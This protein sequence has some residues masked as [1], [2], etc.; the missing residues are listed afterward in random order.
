MDKLQVM[1]NDM[2]RVI[3]GYRRSDH[4]NMKE[5]R[6]TMN[7]M[8]INQLSCYHV[9]LEVQKVLFSNSS[10]QLKEKLKPQTEPSYALRSYSNGDLKV[11]QRPSRGCFGF[12]YTGSKCYNMLPSEIRETQKS[13]PFKRKMKEWVKNNIPD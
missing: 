8:S 13:G 9:L 12:S 5:L 3:K 11:P 10:Q 6:R 4:I 7:M 1:Q 2:L